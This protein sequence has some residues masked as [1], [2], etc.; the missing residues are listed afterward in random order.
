LPPHD[1]LVIHNIRQLITSEPDLFNASDDAGRPLGII[2][3][4]C[5]AVSDGIIKWAGRQSDF[6]D[7]AFRDAGRIDA[8]GHVVLPGLVD[9][10]THAVFAGT[11]EREYEMRVLGTAYMDIARQGGG[12]NATVSAVR[13]ASVDDLVS[14]GLKRLDAMVRKGT[15]TAEIKSGYGLSVEHEIKMLEAMRR[16][17]EEAE[18]EV[19]PTFLGAHEFP[20]EYKDR[21]DRYVDIVCDEM[22]PAVAERRLAEFCDVFCEKGVFT[23]SQS[24]R[25]LSKGKD[26]GLKPKIHAD[27]FAE[28]G[29]ALVAAEVGAVSAGHLGFA[30]RVGLEAMREAGTVAVL[31]PGVSVGLGKLEFADARLMLDMGLDVAVATDFNPG[32]SMVDSLLVIS[33]LACSFMKMTPAEVLLAMTK[34]AAR[35]VS[36]EAAI[37]SITAGKQADLVLFSIPD[38]RY[39]PYHFGGDMVRAVIK[40][41]RVVFNRDAQEAS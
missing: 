29:A 5:V 9:A 39:I 19:I 23:A 28:S 26:Y 8:A 11:R 35:A 37:G 12:I 15:T 10:H 20:P 17:K 32:S 38:F 3:D 18:V 31:L 7:S 1:D 13:Q 14:T 25:I 36:R 34:K 22:I 2:E 33:S 4:A 24:R 41:G 21:R 30:S 27:E 16:L 6:D 40:K